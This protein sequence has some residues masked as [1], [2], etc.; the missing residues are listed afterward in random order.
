MSSKCI[1]AELASHVVTINDAI[2]D[3]IMLGMMLLAF[4]FWLLILI[5]YL[6]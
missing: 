5:T 6:Q 3:N 1:I 4:G 2:H